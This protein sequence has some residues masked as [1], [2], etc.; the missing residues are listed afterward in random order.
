MQHK[1]RAFSQ[2][3]A[4]ALVAVDRLVV[5][6]QMEVNRRRKLSLDSTQEAKGLL[7]SMTRIALR[8]DVAIADMQRGKQAGCPVALIL[9][10][11]RAAATTYRGQ[12]GLRSVQRLNLALLIDA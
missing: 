8:H 2:P 10:G 5:E 4:D 11:V 7:M 1:A 3:V 12:A 6:D 9:V